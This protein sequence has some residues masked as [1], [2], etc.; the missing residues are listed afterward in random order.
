MSPNAI[1]SLL[2]NMFKHNVMIFRHMRTLG[3]YC[4]ALHL[5]LLFTLIWLI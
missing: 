2:Q 3:T 4:M 5:L 1:P